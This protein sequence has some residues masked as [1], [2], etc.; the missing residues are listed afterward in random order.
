MYVLRWVPPGINN[1]KQVYAYVSDSH[2]EKMTRTNDISKARRYDKIPHRRLR[3][4]NELD[5]RKSWECVEEEQA[6]IDAMVESI[7]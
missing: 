4:L 5:W 1:S 3:V 6:L 7:K 2:K